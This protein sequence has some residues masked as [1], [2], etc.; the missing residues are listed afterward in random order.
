MNPNEARKFQYVLDVVRTVFEKYGF[1]PLF[2]PA[3]E[4][5]KLLSAKS[6]DSIKDEI[7]YF[8]DKSKR[9][10]GLR[11]EFTASLA[12][13][14]SNNPNLSKPFKRYQYGK[15]WRY[16]QPQ[17]MRFRE[18]W[19][20]DVDIIG[21]SSIE[22]DAEILS[23]FTECMN[24]LGFKDY[25]VR[26]NSRKVIEEK[27]IKVGITDI[28]SVFRIIDK[29]DKIGEAGVRK[30][31]K[32][33]RI[34]DTKV[35]KVIKNFN[36]PEGEIKELFELAK[37]FGFD[38]KLKFDSTLV[39]GLGYYTGLVYE[40]YAGK[41]LSCGGGGRYDN[42]I[43]QL[44]GPDLP[45]TGISFGVDR[46]V[47]LMDEKQFPK[48]KSKYYIANVNEKVKP[49][50]YKIAKTLRDKGISCDYDLMNRKLGKQMAS[51]S[52]YPYVI[53]VG[54]KEIKQNKVLLRNMISGKE[55]LLDIKDVIKNLK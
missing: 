17:A 24:A 29:M 22:A 52:D 31:L 30:E 37:R 41:G 1:N 49:D 25:Y 46:L 36:N 5:Y 10:L 7:Y 4:D 44:G 12:R 14:V 35:M 27:M 51:A 48:S 55:E 38:K 9:E 13:F 19:Q 53:I 15:V 43:K 26:V 21:S 11:F 8:Q 34:D 6:G 42:L 23:C 18:F 39:R 2:T 45:A 33:K 32:T 47:N 20:A 50:V 54:E 40:V 16:D 3:F 28:E